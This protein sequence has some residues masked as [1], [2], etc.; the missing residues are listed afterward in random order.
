[1]KKAI[2]VGA[3][4]GIGRELAS[5][6]S[7]QGYQVGITGRRTSLLEQLK[8]ENPGS[9]SVKTMDVTDT[10]TVPV[11][12][13]E[14]AL[15]LDGLDLLILCAGTGEINMQ[16]AF[17]T[18]KQTIDT[19][20]SGFTCVAGWA[21]HYFE[22]QRSGHLVAISSV[23][24]LR[25]S[26]QAPAYNASK[27]YQVNYMEGLRQKAAKLN[28]TVFI[29]D[30]RPG[31][32]DTRMAKGKGLFWVM[33]VDKSARQIFAAIKKRRQTAYVTKRWRLV[34]KILQWIPAFLYNRM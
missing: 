9:Y 18:E 21:F 10:S 11:H 5:L 19:N 2:I 14:L 31:L 15:E 25:G 33:P 24:G 29:T 22:K 4:S 1:M 26:G 8:S 28:G 3:T 17:E 13:D 30:I 6:L 34:A 16:L 12:L 20:V 27:A 23:A 32:V 7:G